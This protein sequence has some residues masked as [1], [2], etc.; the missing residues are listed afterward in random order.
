MTNP[1]SI[2]D[3]PDP[4]TV[5]CV[6]ETISE[7]A[8]GKSSDSPEFRLYK[9]ITDNPNTINLIIDRGAGNNSKVQATC[10]EAVD[11][12]NKGH[13]NWLYMVGNSLWPNTNMSPPPPKISTLQSTNIMQGGNKQKTKK[14]KKIK[15]LKKNKKSYKRKNLKIKKTNKKKS[16]TNKIKYLKMR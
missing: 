2:Y 14:V 12:L 5:K 8:K 15:Y 11:I 16:K 13:Q 3:P 7:N 4:E 10:S 6:I 1:P 9:Q